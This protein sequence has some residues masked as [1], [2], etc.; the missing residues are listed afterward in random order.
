MPLTLL[1]GH[2]GGDALHRLARAIV[3]I[4][5]EVRMAKAIVE[6]LLQERKS[7]RPTLLTLS[8]TSLALHV[9]M[10][11]I[12]RAHARGA[13]KLVKM[14]R[15]WRCHPLEIQRVLREGLGPAGRD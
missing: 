1:K 15:M 10:R 12:Q 4:D 11:S 5:A 7:E 8:E 6:Q 3:H 9:S 13:I 14:G 2:A